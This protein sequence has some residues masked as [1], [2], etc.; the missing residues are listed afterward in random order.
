MSSLPQQSLDLAVGVQTRISQLDQ[1]DTKQNISDL[2]SAIQLLAQNALSATPS[3]DN[4][5]PSETTV[6][7]PT[8]SPVSDPPSGT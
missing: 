6:D 8:T 4:P 3:M 1:I 7:V 5:D 2:C